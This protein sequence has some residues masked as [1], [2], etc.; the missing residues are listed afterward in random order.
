MTGCYYSRV[1]DEKAGFIKQVR[2]IGERST[3]IT[4]QWNNLE[5][6]EKFYLRN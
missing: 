6:S 3:L 1:A 2:P 4:E 5:S